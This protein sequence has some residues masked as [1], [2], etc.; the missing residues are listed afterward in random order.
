VA[1]DPASHK[2]KIR[3]SIEG[4]QVRIAFTKKG[5]AGVHVY[6]RASGSADWLLLGR[7]SS[8]PYYDA[9]ALALPGV[10]ESREYRVRGLLADTE[11]GMASDIVRVVFG[12]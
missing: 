5:L 6:R 12:G 1:A 11:V 4:G 8:S 7:A 9:S 3:A 2:P 10:P